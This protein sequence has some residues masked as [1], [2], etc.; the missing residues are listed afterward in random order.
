MPL[1]GQI[2][3]ICCTI[4]V[5]PLLLS[6]LTNCQILH[7]AAC[8][9]SEEGINVCIFPVCY[10]YISGV[11]RCSKCAFIQEGILNPSTKPELLPFKHST[12]YLVALAAGEVPIVPIVIANSAYIF[13]KPTQ[14]FLGGTVRVRVL[15]PI[16]SKAKKGE[17]RERAVSRLMDHTRDAIL[18]A[19]ERILV[20]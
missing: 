9:I 13:H 18:E 12:F 1:L 4:F 10:N 5:D 16:S 11:H 8:T 14:T 17:S 3:S 19:L 20:N 6:G 7:N 2:L 15:P